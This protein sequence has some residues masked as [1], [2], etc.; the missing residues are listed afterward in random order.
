MTMIS[1]FLPLHINTTNRP[2]FVPKT[3]FI[4]VFVQNS[5]H[6]VMDLS[7]NLLL[8]LLRFYENFG[9]VWPYGTSFFITNSFSVDSVK[10]WPCKFNVGLYIG[11]LYC[12]RF[13]PSL[14]FMVNLFTLFFMEC[15]F[16]SHMV[17]E[18]FY[19]LVLLLNMY[20][21]ISEVFLCQIQFL[22][23]Q[24]FQLIL[25]VYKNLINLQNLISY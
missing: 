8:Y 12:L 6:P 24:S 23:E 18:E 2:N 9:L 7:H 4:I 17:S 19:Y 15:F 3:L 5:L 20:V 16:F 22:I 13:C 1:C 21:D 25:F 14:F 11:I 10:W